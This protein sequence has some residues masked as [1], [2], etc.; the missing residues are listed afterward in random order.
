MH[1]LLTNACWRL[2]DLATTNI[3]K[4]NTNN[5]T[6]IWV[7]KF[8]TFQTRSQELLRKDTDQRIDHYLSENTQ[9]NSRLEQATVKQERI[10]SID[11]SVYSWLFD[12]T[13]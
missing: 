7:F 6:H 11:Y 4:V 1:T 9:L 10:V 3:C 13:F 8:P 5:R 2:A 12:K